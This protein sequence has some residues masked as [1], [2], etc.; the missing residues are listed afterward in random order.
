MNP[1][2]RTD[3]I[4]QRLQAAFSPTDLEV[5]DESHA[6]AG[7]A[8]AAGGLGH[9]RIRITAAAFEGISRIARHQRIY[10]ALGSLM[11][12]DIHALAIAAHAPGECLRQTFHTSIQQGTS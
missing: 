2:E 12:T 9:F 1:L 8:G 10:A 3:A 5:E 11:E 6:H 4:H 7:H